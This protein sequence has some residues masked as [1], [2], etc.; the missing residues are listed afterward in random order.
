MVLLIISDTAILKKNGSSIVLEPPLREIEF[1]SHN[2]SKI[3]WLG[4]KKIDQKDLCRSP[5]NSKFELVSMPKSGGNTFLAK[6][7]IFLNIISYSKTVYKYMKTADIVHFRMPSVPG[8]IGLI[9]NL[10]FN[11]NKGWIKYAGD[12]AGNAPFGYNIQRHFLRYYKKLPVT[13]LSK[14]HSNG[15]LHFIPNPCLSNTEL[16]ENNINGFNKDFNG[17]INLLFVGSLSPYKRPEILIK[18][19]LKLINHKNIGVLN[20]IGDGV[21]Y[22]KIKGLIKDKGDKIILRGFCSRNEIDYY[23]SI[24]HLLVCPSNSEG[25]PKVIAEA[26]SFGCVPVVTALTGIKDLIKHKN[27]GW[28]LDEK[29][30]LN[31]LN[32]SL[33]NLLNNKELLYSISKN[34][35]KDSRIF[36]YDK[37]NKIIENFIH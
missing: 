27:T 18:S 29:D 14:K 8:I 35:I 22:K 20:I 5:S 2:F 11:K 24:S 12:W 19:Y 16:K 10:Y 26:M 33:K 15:H 1:L 23:Y 36:T 6:I 7:G 21:L 30:T 34:A 9:I 13:I 28:L 32:D 31:N 3:I 4:F 25:F 37:F 17:K